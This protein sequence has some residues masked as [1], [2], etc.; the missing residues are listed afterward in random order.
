VDGDGYGLLSRMRDP[1]ALDARVSPYA[2]DVAGNGLDED[3]VAGDLPVGPPWVEPAAPTAAFTTRPDVVLIFLETF[4]ADALGARVRGKAVTPTFDALAAAGIAVP[5]AFS[6]NGYTVQSRYHL[7]SGRLVARVGADTLVDDFK[8]NGYEVAYFSAQDEE[9]GPEAYGVGFDRADVAYDAR[10]D[11]DRRY[12]TFSTAGSLGVASDVLLE[13]IGQFLARRD[14]TRPLFLFVNF[15]DTHFPY[16]HPKM[17]PLVSAVH[18]AQSDIAPK[19]A[20]RLREMY[21]N[22]AANVDAAAGR[23]LEDLRSHLGHDPA[24][25]VTADHGESLFEEGFLGHGYALNDVQTQVPLVVANLPAVLPS[26][27]GH[28]DVRWSLL[29]ALT[30]GEPASVGRIERVPGRRVFQYLGVVERPMAI[31]FVMEAGRLGYD[32]RD[33]TIDDDGASTAPGAAAE[34]VVARWRALV[35][36]W[37]RVVLAQSARA[38]PAGDAVQPNE[39]HR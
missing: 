36:F 31:G 3:G 24:V 11:R 18:L 39:Q 19:S 12:T 35:H 6:H 4:R 29:A 9:F 33:G 14:P 2:P 27:A 10:Q 28:A 17:L 26:L 37:E 30:S 1:D 16:W 32:F 38:G 22:S 21:L 34:A 7:M 8:R 25:V 15:Y 23:L 5:R 13:R 20:D